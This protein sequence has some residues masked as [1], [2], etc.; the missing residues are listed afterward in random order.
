MSAR[1]RINSSLRRPG[2]H[3]IRVKGTLPIIRKLAFAGREFRSTASRS[4]SQFPTRNS[5]IALRRL[6][7]EV[8]ARGRGGESRT[9]AGGVP[10]PAGDDATF[11]ASGGD[12]VEV[13]FATEG[14]AGW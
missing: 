14:C 8:I 12:D 2:R 7:R 3:T 13:A 1:T 4:A 6:E 5:T 10:G 11:L 9:R